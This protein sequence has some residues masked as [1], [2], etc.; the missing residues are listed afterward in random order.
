[1]NP[2]G[3][4][5][6]LHFE[7]QVNDR[8]WTSA[9]PAIDPE[10]LPEAGVSRPLA[11]RRLQRKDATLFLSADPLAATAV[12][13]IVDGDHLHLPVHPLAER[14]FEQEGLVRSG[15]IRVSASYRTVF[16]EPDAGGLFDR[17]VPPGQVL[18][19]HRPLGADP[20]HLRRG[21]QYRARTVA[22]HS[23]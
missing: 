14:R 9:A 6:L 1:M 23:R 16:F 19:G 5:L 20:A 22:R 13:Q 2:V 21:T 3:G 12:D 4:T 15:R 11:W 18:I 10:L 17:W 8:R 7:Q